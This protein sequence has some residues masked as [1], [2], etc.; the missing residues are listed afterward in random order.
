MFFSSRC[1]RCVRDTG[2]DAPGSRD[3]SAC[4]HADPVGSMVVRGSQ[5]LHPLMPC[6]RDTL[7]AR[8]EYDALVT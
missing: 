8:T 7:G 1:R 4:F 2:V 3:E 6:S 5:D